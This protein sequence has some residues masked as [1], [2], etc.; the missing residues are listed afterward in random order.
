MLKWTTI[1][2]GVAGT[3]MGIYVVSTNS[4]PEDQV[5]PAP[6]S[7]PSV[8][9]FGRGIAATGVVEAQTRNLN[10]SA[11]EGAVVMQVFKQVGERVKKGEALFELDTRV[12]HA[13]RERAQAALLSARAQLAVAEARLARW[14]A[15]PRQEELPPLEAA[16]NRAK[17]HLRDQQQM[18]AELSTAGQGMAAS[19]NEIDRRRF[20]VEVAQ[21][22]LAAAE[23]QLALVRSGAWSA[24]K[25]VGQAEVQQAQAGVKEAEAAIRAIDLRIER[26]TVSSPVDGVVLKRNIEP[27][28]FA[29]TGPGVPAAIVV[30]DISTLRVRAR[31]D[32]EDAPQLRDGAPGAAR[33]RGLAAETIP[34]KWMWVEPLAQPKTDLTG[35]NTERVDTRVV[36]VLFQ[37]EGTPKSRIFPGQVVDVYIQTAP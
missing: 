32:E 14:N 1:L 4:R 25:S 8:N 3:A 23:A 31:V 33:V 28:A 6:A 29:A 5:R 7:P 10:V 13:E 36:E 35:S 24:D 18:L 19:G 34:L 20:Q 9:P 27:G 11:P 16:V 21:A 22:D 2:L 12:L 26:L 30:G 37:I 15:S 17:A